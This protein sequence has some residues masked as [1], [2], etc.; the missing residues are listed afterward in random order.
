MDW[1]LSYDYEELLTELKSD[2]QEF[3]FKHNDEIYIVRDI[4]QLH[5]NAFVAGTKY[6][7]SIIDYYLSQEEIEDED[8]DKIEKMS[9]K[10]VVDEMEH[11]N[12]MF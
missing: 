3:D 4:T 5:T 2:I 1:K 7:A 10:A 8:K 9:V 6:Y 11:M 12:E